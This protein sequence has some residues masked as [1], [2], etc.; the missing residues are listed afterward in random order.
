[1]SELHN[2]DK[3]L[4][5]SFSDFTPDAPNVW[6]GIEQGVQAAQ[7]GNAVGAAGA[8]KGGIGLVT[9]II[10]VVA[11]SASLVTAVVLINTKTEETP[12]QVA[13]TQPIEVPVEPQVAVPVEPEVAAPIVAEAPKTEQPQPKHQVTLNHHN[14]GEKVKNEQRVTGPAAN[15]ET[16]T[17]PAIAKTTAGNDVAAKTTSAPAPVTSTSG[18]VNETGTTAA[19]TQ[20]YTADPAA[21]KE[22]VK[23]KKADPPF[24]PNAE[25]GEIY[26]RPTIPGSFSP[27]N[28]GL[29]E[30]YVI[31]IDDEVMYSLMI[32]DRNGRVVFESDNKSTTWDGRDMRTGMMC[33][34]GI[35]YFSFRYQFQGSQQSHK[36]TGM[37]SL[38]K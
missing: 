37:I 17:T 19:K 23:E 2:I 33:E 6:Q 11:V 38:I 36:K 22:E 20:N 21:K 8:V 1:M 16:T 7:A 34:Q 14:E 12:A 25:D 10:G 18:S 35:Y 24:N 31:V 4:K 32:L 30:K 28:N 15:P 9:K 5:E 29:N 27:D 13:I 26:E 3:L